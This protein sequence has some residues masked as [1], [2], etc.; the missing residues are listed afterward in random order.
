[1][2]GNDWVGV[3][4]QSKCRTRI[5]RVAE[6]YHKPLNSVKFWQVYSFNGVDMF[7]KL[8]KPKA[9]LDEATT[10]WLFDT[11]SW[12]LRN[13]DARVFYDETILVIPSNQ[14]FP[15]REDSAHGM[16]NLIFSQVKEYAGLK[17]WPTKLTS[18]AKDM[19]AES[20]RIEIKGALRGS[21]GIMPA[22]DVVHQLS[23]FYNSDQLR[24]S[25]VL[26]ADFAH[27]LG[28]HLGSMSQEPPPG[29]VENWPHVTEVVAVFMGFGLMMA[30]S[31]HTVKI[32]SCGSCSGPAVERSNA[33][34]QYDITYA[35]AIFSCLKE[36]PA[37]EVL[38]HLKKS[39]RPF[40]KKAAREVMSKTKELNQI[41]VN[42][43]PT[44]EH[45]PG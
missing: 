13:L 4:C 33:L 11:F 1:M 28:H 19:P 8:L 29:G 21:K 20:P 18:M 30:N 31:A 22:A 41:R 37:K 26:I 38:V 35:L 7:S 3:K 9:V 24:D 43:S 6:C 40:Y 12:A 14:Y 15:G 36:I 34:S 42:S 25:E 10:L 27:V 23:I 45:A 16:A 39:L 32:R 17:H 44:V 2:T 5:S